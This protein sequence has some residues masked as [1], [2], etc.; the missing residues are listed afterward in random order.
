[1]R[2]TTTPAS[3]SSAKHVRVAGE[4]AGARLRDHYGG[5]LPGWQPL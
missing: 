3:D 5:G 1:M 2:T 4:Y